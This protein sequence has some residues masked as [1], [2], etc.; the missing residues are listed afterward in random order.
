[1]VRRKRITHE[2]SL[3]GDVFET[4]TRAFFFVK[5]TKTGN[6]I[7]TV[8][9]PTRSVTNLFNTVTVLLVY[10]FEKNIEIW[11]YVIALKNILRNTVQTK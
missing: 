11:Y 8:N 9:V 7:K 3:T 5:I 1:M 4:K 6:T 10:R 2:W